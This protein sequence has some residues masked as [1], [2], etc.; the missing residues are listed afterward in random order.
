MSQPHSPSPR[1]IPPVSTPEPVPAEDRAIEP[2]S[3]SSETSG[4]PG[5]PRAFRRGRQ[6]IL[7]NEPSI[8]THICIKSGRPTYR[9]LE[10]ALRSAKN[11]LTWFGKR[12]T[13]HVGLCRKSFDDYRVAGALTW[14]VLGIGVLMLVAGLATLSWLTIAVG[15]IAIGICGVFRATSP[16]TSPD[17]TEERATVIGASP[18]YLKKF[19]EYPE[20]TVE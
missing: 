11:P 9:E 8:P 17:A 2:S 19:E 10:V 7:E 6:L 5:I 16:V 4:V 1:P 12:P 3:S 15:V 13:L 18:S 14:S 20:L